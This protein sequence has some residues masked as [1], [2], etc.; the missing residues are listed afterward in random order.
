MSGLTWVDFLMPILS[1]VSLGLYT[2]FYF[3][4]IEWA[5]A[6]KV[7]GI[8]SIYPLFVALWSFIFLHETIQ[9]M[10]YLGI[11]LAVIGGCVLSS[12]ALKIIYKT[13]LRNTE[14]CS[15]RNAEF[16]EKERATEEEVR[17][18]EAK[19]MQTK[20]YGE[21]W[22]PFKKRCA[23]DKEVSKV[24][25]GEQ[26]PLL[27]EQGENEDDEY[28]EISVNGNIQEE[29]GNGEETASRGKYLR[30]IILGV[31]PIPI[32]MSGNDFFAKISVGNLHRNN[33]SGLNS[34]GLGAVLVCMLFRKDVREHYLDELKFN[35]FFCAII[36]V[37][38]I[39]ATYL[40]ICGMIGLE[41]PIVSS[42]TASR[43]LFVL[44]FETIFRVSKVPVS[45]CFGFKLLPILCVIAGTI[46]M[47]VYA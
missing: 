21:W 27:G 16:L 24:G 13:V 25:E 43:P 6:S 8:E 26:D 45:H 47:S 23:Q 34:L 20:G 1:G 33:V 15:A 9:P 44:I 12:D 37:M 7:A 40:I 2:I 28:T 22:Y 29:T 32:L 11:A 19:K 3:F 36:E 17:E 30:K 18:E 5:E 46:I 14:S 31:L 4:A 42:L 10:T 41:A 39:S 35:W 38:S